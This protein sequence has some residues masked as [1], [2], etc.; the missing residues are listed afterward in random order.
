MS[1][2]VRMDLGSRC[3]TDDLVGCVYH[4]EDFI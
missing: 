4:V 1:Q 2:F 3:L